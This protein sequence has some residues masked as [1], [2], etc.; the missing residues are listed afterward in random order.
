MM[1]TQFLPYLQANSKYNGSKDP[2][3]KISHM[4]KPNLMKQGYIDTL[5]QLSTSLKFN[6]LPQCV[7]I[8]YFS[9]CLKVG[10][11][12]QGNSSALCGVNHSDQDGY[13]QPR[14]QPG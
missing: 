8:Y 5:H 14:A 11:A 1:Q 12:Q 7:L 10:W 9:C 2:T 3:C 13:I 6:D 4:V